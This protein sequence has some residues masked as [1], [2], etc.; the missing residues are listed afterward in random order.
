MRLPWVTSD[1]SSHRPPNVVCNAKPITTRCSTIEKARRSHHLASII[2]LQETL[3]WRLTALY[4]V[5]DTGRYTFRSL[6]FPKVHADRL[7]SSSGPLAT[8]GRVFPPKSLSRLTA[9]TLTTCPPIRVLG[10]LLDHITDLYRL[11]KDSPS[12]RP[13]ASGR[14]D[15]PYQTGVEMGEPRQ[16]PAGAGYRPLAGLRG[17]PRRWCN[18]PGGAPAE[19]GPARSLGMAPSTEILG[20]SSLARR[21]E[22]S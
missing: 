18:R 22:R 4:P 17:R 3:Q 5:T 19:D 6:S 21:S 14:A 8:V 20:T 10:G 11:G 1:A 15:P 13:G 2:P 16:L 7:R 12:R 9:S